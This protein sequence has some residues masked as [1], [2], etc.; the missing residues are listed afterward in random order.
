MWTFFDHL[1]KLVAIVQIWLQY[2]YDL[3]L[4]IF[5]HQWGC[6]RLKMRAELTSLRRWELMAMLAWDFVL[7]PTSFAK[8]RVFV[9]C[10]DF[11]K[12]LRL[13]GIGHYF[14]NSDQGSRLWWN[15]GSRAA[16]SEVW[17]H[18]GEGYGRPGYQTTSF[19]GSSLGIS[20]IDSSLFFYRTH[21]LSRLWLIFEQF[22]IW[23]LFPT[24]LTI[25]PF[26]LFILTIH[27]KICLLPH[28]S[29]TNSTSFP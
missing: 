1:T 29:P 12:I 16:P 14:E 17:D 3:E 20:L 2:S 28:L 27:H 19:S 18:L 10:W 26:L 4:K 23:S 15:F 24:I 25:S 11:P 7:T 22:S 5:G 9:D 8:L 13:E 21:C 6:S